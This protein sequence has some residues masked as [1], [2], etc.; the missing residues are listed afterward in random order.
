MTKMSKEQFDRLENE[1]KELN[2]KI[3]ALYEFLE[4]RRDNDIDLQLL[5]IQLA[6]MST[7]S[8]VLELRIENEKNY[9]SK[10][11]P[12]WYEAIPECGIICKAWNEFER[13]RLTLIIGFENS[14][15]IGEYGLKFRDAEPLDLTPFIKEK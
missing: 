3:N 15:Y 1:L 13:K 6:S 11:E 4:A 7:Y 12:K 5:A 10:P 2:T 14:S 9:R 8:N